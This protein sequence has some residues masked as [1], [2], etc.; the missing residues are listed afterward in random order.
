MEN[1]RE[2]INQVFQETSTIQTTRPNGIYIMVLRSRTLASQRNISFPVEILL[3]V[4]S[5]TAIGLFARKS[6]VLKAGMFR[7]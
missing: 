4:Y 1:L 3:G 2:W 7:L 6:D 5:A